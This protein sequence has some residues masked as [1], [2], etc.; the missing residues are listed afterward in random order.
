MW[1]AES[2]A[3]DTV[4]SDFAENVVQVL[5]EMKAPGC[6]WLDLVPINP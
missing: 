6:Q 5:I 2:A 1:C 4:L 3:I